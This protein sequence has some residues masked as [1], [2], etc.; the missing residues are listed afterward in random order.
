[1]SIIFNE[2]D[3]L[4]VTKPTIDNIGKIDNNIQKSENN[5]SDLIDNM[6]PISE[7]D[8]IIDTNINA[9]PE[10]DSDDK[11]FID[12]M[13]GNTAMSNIT[14]TINES[15]D[16][17]T[18]LESVGALYG[19]PSQNILEDNSL[20]HIKVVGD[21]II[22]PNLQNPS[23]N[24][25]AIVCSIGSVLDNISQRINDKLDDYQSN[26]IEKY[27]IEDHIAKSAS[28]SKGNVIDRYVDSNGDEVL[29]Y[30]SG[31]VDMANTPEA[32]KLVGDLRANDKIP[33]YEPKK[34]PERPSYF[35]DEDDIMKGIEEYQLIEVEKHDISKEINESYY[36]MDLMNKFKFTDTLGYDLFKSYGVDYIK[37]TNT[38]VQEAASKKK[39]QI[40]SKDIKYM[41]FDNKNIIDAINYFNKARAAQANVKRGH[42]NRE[43][44]ISDPNWS[45]GITALNKQF[46]CHLNVRFFDEPSGFPN[47]S[48]IVMNEYKPKMF[49]SKQKGFQL[50]GLPIDIFIENDGIDFGSPEDIKMFGQGVVSTFLHEI[51]HN[52]VQVIRETNDQF[53]ATIVTTMQ[54]AQSMRSGKARRILFTNYVNSLNEMNG[55]QL[56][57]L[58]RKIL[59]K[60]LCIISTFKNED[61]LNKLKNEINN[62]ESNDDIDAIIEKY[63]KAVKKHDPKRKYHK[64]FIISIIEMV[65]GF[66]PPIILTM[67]GRFPLIAFFLSGIVIGRGIGNFIVALI[68]KSWN[69]QYSSQR[70]YEESYCDMFA[71]MYKLPVVFFYTKNE[72]ASSGEKK[73]TANDIEKERLQRL[74]DLEKQLYQNINAIYPTSSERNYASVKVAQQM[75]NYPKSLDPATKKYLQWIVDNYSSLLDTN[76]ERNYNDVTFDP[77]ES[78]DLDMHLDKLINDNNLTITESFIDWMLEGY[79]EDDK[80][81]DDEEFVDE[82]DNLVQA[83]FQAKQA[84]DGIGED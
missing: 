37:P 42:V 24:T 54:I 84:V 70:F 20:N 64:R 2:A 36:H 9:K 25:K 28:P 41:K 62:I 79:E 8:E 3:G 35:S 1:M 58:T 30:D 66:L 18:A 16:L 61:V 22:A 53:L 27:K 60:K 69:D 48:T 15:K 45:K 72:R 74:I 6:E 19:I 4:V 63:E 33:H 10:L 77:N 51:F 32:N 26:N 76:I 29:V 55:K 31:L 73:Y 44:L 46:D 21:N 52:I 13:N 50:G 49:I 82:N 38:F 47:A 71:A 57:R 65:C 80:E 23:A 81:E 67:Q 39:K 7:E 43:K 83:N 68:L 75:L 5:K 59:V 56:N 11:A 40:T 78:T 14:S 12:K 17:I 34:L